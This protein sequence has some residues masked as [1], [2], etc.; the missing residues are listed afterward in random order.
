M[1][2]ERESDILEVIIRDYIAGAT[3]VSSKRVLE[4]T[5][6]ELSPASIRSIMADLEDAGY[7]A[8]PHISA[9]RMP[10]QKGYRFFVDHMMEV[11]TQL[12][13]R[14]EGR[15]HSSRH[16]GEAL[17]AIAEETHLCAIAALTGQDLPM[18]FGL[19][20]LFREPEFRDGEFIA[21]FGELLDAIL[22]KYRTYGEAISETG[23]GVFIE[24]E[25][26]IPEAHSASIMISALPN[27]E[28]FLLTLG[29]ARMDY[30]RTAQ[31]LRLSAGILRP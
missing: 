11:E 31:I 12:P 18:N 4:I 13:D 28:G 16:I 19:S 30:E 1:I 14:L 17:R 29:P 20:E 15:I 7:I 8:Q 10:T 9:G 3:P 23:F 27:A 22:E 2:T 26:I 24:R 21:E 5:E 6:I 25:N